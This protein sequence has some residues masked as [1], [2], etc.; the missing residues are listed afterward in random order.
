VEKQ[1]E[2]KISLIVRKKNLLEKLNLFFFNIRMNDSTNDENIRKNYRLQAIINTF[3]RQDVQT[4]MIDEAIKNLEKDMNKIVM[5]QSLFGKIENQKG[6]FITK[7]R[8]DKYKKDKYNK[9]VKI[10]V[11]DFKD[12]SG[13]VLQEE[14]I[15]QLLGLKG[16]KSR[17]TKKA[18]KRKSKKTKKTK[19]R[20]TKRRKTQRRKN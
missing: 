7:Y 19:K 10:I 9:L 8:K 5:V 11:N 13:T 3:R 6:F 1:N 17:K 12:E 20:K 2:K 16:G 15:K 4:E 14:R 18:N